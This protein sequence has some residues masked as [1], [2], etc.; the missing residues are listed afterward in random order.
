MDK[1][2][3][4]FF[5]CYF[6]FD[7]DENIRFKAASNDL[8]EV[9]LIL[10]ESHQLNLIL[11]PL[12]EETHYHYKGNWQL[13]NDFYELTFTRDKAGE[14]DLSIVFDDSRERVI[15]INTSQVKFLKTESRIKIWGI[16]CVKE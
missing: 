8:A 16:T 6:I 7:I 15:V 11:K 5:I 1:I 10:N 2:L 12:Q 4:F 9:S 3:P 13:K 14:P